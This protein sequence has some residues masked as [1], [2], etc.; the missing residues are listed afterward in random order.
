[1]KWMAWLQDRKMQKSCRNSP[2]SRSDHVRLDANRCD[3]AVLA[4]A[5]PR[6]QDDV[7]LVS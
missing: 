6:G 7:Q 1:M 5:D 2:S 3:R 4:Y